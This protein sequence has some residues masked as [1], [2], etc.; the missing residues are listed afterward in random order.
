MS[1]NAIE[2]FYIYLLE[3]SLSYMVEMP[4][5]EIDGNC[6]HSGVTLCE[7]VNMIMKYS[8]SPRLV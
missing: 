1:F 2:T 8:S 4:F 6:F 5:F 7:S 3:T